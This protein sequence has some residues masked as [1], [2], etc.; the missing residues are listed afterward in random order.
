MRKGRE[1]RKDMEKKRDKSGRG[2]MKRIGKR[3]RFFFFTRKR[4]YEI[5]NA[6]VWSRRCI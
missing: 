6:L 5:S 3:V 4:G 1:K 2:K